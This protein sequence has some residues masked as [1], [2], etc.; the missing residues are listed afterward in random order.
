MIPDNAVLT[1]LDITLGLIVFVTVLLL[2]VLMISSWLTYWL[3]TQKALQKRQ[4]LEQQLLTQQQLHAQEL[5][6]LT[7][8]NEKLSAQAVD[9]LNELTQRALAT[10]NEAFLRLAEENFR[11][12]S[13]AATADLDKKEK[14]I[15][16]LLSPIR[17]AL[18][19]TE[20]QI[21]SI[22][23]ERQHMFGS[24]SQHIQS[25]AESQTRLQQETQSLVTALRRPE[26]RGQWGEMTLKR[27]AE[28]AGMVDQC[29]FVEQLSTDTEQGKI[30]PDMIVRMPDSRELIIDA[31]TP[32]DAYLT[33]VQ[34]T[35]EDQKSLALH[36][37][38]RRVKDR[39]KE[40]ASKNYWAQFKQTPDY[41]V[42]FI[43]GDQ[44]LS[45][46]LEIDQQLLEYAL[47]NRV[48]LATPTS[49][50]ALL[51]AV[52][53]GWRQQAVAD[54]AEQIQKL[55][56]DLYHRMA[57]FAEHFNKVGHSLDK[58]IDAYNSAVGSMQRNV[59]PGARKFVDMG[60]ENK[61]DVTVPS[62]VEAAARKVNVQ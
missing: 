38:A 34:E 27:L 3:A 11:K 43:P 48:I 15:E 41:V 53:F 28:L 58:S 55:G 24:L 19:K 23:K 30:R 22:E 26:V 17:E 62:I 61:K 54:N 2:A 9:Q 10:N 32:L 37:H 31:K 1:T 47:S 56:E 8:A 39:V 14:S 36:R 51:R 16:N 20:Q 57:T 6:S 42:L 13:A 50:I 29:D 46:A 33:A 44:F 40:L 5:A 60:I 21:H 12:H 52:A 18:N 59:L 35:N 45:T 49:L 4:Q 7:A 25:M